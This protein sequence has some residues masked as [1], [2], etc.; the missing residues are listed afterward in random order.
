MFAPKWPV[1]KSVLP[2][3]ILKD[4]YIAVIGVILCNITQSISKVLVMGRLCCK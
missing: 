3:V 4:I 1:S 2:F